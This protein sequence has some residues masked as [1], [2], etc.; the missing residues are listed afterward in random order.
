VKVSN[1]I[2]AVVVAVVVV[3]ITLDVALQ[4][5][6]SDVSYIFFRRSD[7]RIDRQA[8]KQMYMYIPQVFT[9][10]C[11]SQYCPELLEPI[12]SVY[13]SHFVHIEKRIYVISYT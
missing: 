13:T 10:N 5:M 6:V 4:N 9:G 2:I 7:D 3:V 12:L 11:T 1:Q 8:D